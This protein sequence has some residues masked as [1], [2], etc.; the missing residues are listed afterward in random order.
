[1]WRKSS[2]A[3]ALTA[4]LALAGCTGSEGA[5]GSQGQPGPA[6][7]VVN[8]NDGTSTITCPGSAPVTVSDGATPTPCT[9]VD[10]LDGTKTITCPG[11][12][13]TVADGVS[14]AQL[15]GTVTNSLTNLPISGATITLDPLVPG[16]TLA[17]NS[18]GVYSGTLPI[19]T[20]KLSFSATGYTKADVTIVL[21]A[22]LAK[23][24][25]VKIVPA[26]PVVVTATP[27]AATV[28]P[29]GTSTLT[30]SVLSFSGA[31]PTSYTWTQ[32]S[33]V[34][35]AL[36]ATNTASINVTLGGVE[37]LKAELWTLATI[38]ERL[39]VVPV[40]PFSHEEA[41]AAV[42]EVSV[43]AS[44]GK[45]YTGTVTVS[46]TLPVGWSSGIAN[47]PVGVPV[48]LHAPLAKARATLTALA[49]GSMTDGATFTI[50][51]GLH[52]VTFEFDSDGT[53]TAA[54]GGTK[55]GDAGI[56]NVRVAY[57]GPP[58]TTVAADQ[59][60]AI[61]VASAMRSA[62]NGADG[63]DVTAEILS[64]ASSNVVELIADNVGVTTASLSRS[65]ATMPITA[66]GGDGVYGW[67]L[68]APDGTTDATGLLDN[69]ASPNPVFTP[70]SE[71]KYLATFAA[72]LGDETLAIHVG[73]WEGAISGIGT[74]GTPVSA[75]CTGLCHATASGVD[76]RFDLWRR[77]GHAQI[78]TQNMDTVPGHYSTAC[79]EC[80][81]VG[82]NPDVVNGGIDDA[83]EWAEFLGAYS[84]GSGALH[85]AAGSWAAIVTNQSTVAK[86]ANIQ[87]ETCHGPGSN[88]MQAGSA[89]GAT[90][91]ASNPA[92]VSLGSEVCGVCHGEPARHGRFQQ[93]LEA[94][95]AD[96]E[97]A[98]D[99][100]AVEFRSVSKTS[101][102][103]GHCGRCHAGEGFIAWLEEPNLMNAIGQTAL[104]ASV[105]ASTSSVANP[106]AYAAYLAD[107]VGMTKD[108]IHGQDCVVCHDPHDQGTTSGEPN[109][110]K[111]RVT[112]S[113]KM[114][115]S[116]F[117]AVN[118]G[119][120]ALCITCHNSRFGALVG[121]AIGLNPSSYENTPHAACQGDAFMGY[122]AYF[123]DTGMRS[124]HANIGDTCVNCHMERTKPP[125][126]FSYNGAGTNHAFAASLDICA[127]CHGPGFDGEGLA[128]QF[129]LGLEDLGTLYASIVKS[130]ITAYLNSAFKG[131]RGKIVV[132][133]V[134]PVVNHDTFT[135]ADGRGNTKVFEFLLSGSLNVATNVKVSI[136]ATDSP[137]K[138]AAAIAS[139]INGATTA[140]SSS[141]PYGFVAGTSFQVTAF[142]KV[143]LA[144][145]QDPGAEVFLVL[146]YATGL[147]TSAA[148]TTGSAALT[149]TPFAE[150]A[151]GQGSAVA[152]AGASYVETLAD[153]T[154]KSHRIDDYSL[155]A[156][157]QAP[158]TVEYVSPTSYDVT[159]ATPLAVKPNRGAGVDISGGAGLPA[160]LSK[161][162]ISLGGRSG[163]LRRSIPTG[164]ANELYAN[165]TVK[166]FDESFDTFWKGVWNLGLLTGDA[167]NGIHNPSWQAAIL[168]NTYSKLIG[169]AACMAT[170][171]ASSGTTTTSGC[172]L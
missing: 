68:L 52:V 67:T 40:V 18:S 88:P 102:G 100:S 35:A 63:L 70:A 129:A 77:S 62:V 143:D 92:R 38:P 19:G 171:W 120:G 137:G 151:A 138:I 75:G 116:G 152:F 29:G 167:S 118:V 136:K 28:N 58:V 57:K 149:V 81:A 139:A 164:D 157:T 106:A 127:D 2:L 74:D 50:N 83:S 90:S 15:S 155:I 131:V 165:V 93:W 99:E 98:I 133:D 159:F 135:V 121:D 1:M 14:V 31:T 172:S 84:D 130:R 7:T 41:A 146:D 22:T 32:K 46:A 42:F 65:D 128:A 8:N 162:R 111:V 148:I 59:S 20:Y 114:L 144:G 109:T 153:G 134:V 72:Y 91:G 160:T 163:G 61:E 33:G 122:N 79:L 123:V 25:N 87:C 108:K 104:G 26:A 39:R 5:A 11:G 71:G 97:L 80:H 145:V 140:T 107:T 147:L 103:P 44:D 78:F 34:P 126:E 96:A 76:A 113:T 110:A 27:S 16:V 89:H 154:T 94:G 169:S 170:A 13:V 105:V 85:S 156:V 17:T 48:M 37:A 125:A 66:F 9:T 142:S 54:G 49:G 6:C 168:Q 158:A 12:S 112:G 95:H 47:V 73:S 64:F 115:P 150:L 69:P 55:W 43:L 166:L 119:R 24:V 60:T 51:D 56:T 132:S 101:A 82:Y 53:P 161:I 21:V 4:S 117:A 45:T 3:A 23:T 36:S 86:L 30:A 10:N 141:V 124:A